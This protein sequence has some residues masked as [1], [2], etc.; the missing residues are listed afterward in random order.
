MGVKIGSY[1]PQTQTPSALLQIGANP[2][3]RPV[4]P[5]VAIGAGL[6]QLGKGLTDVSTA[7]LIKDN[8]DGVARAGKAGSDANKY[9]IDLLEEEK[10]NL[11]GDPNGFAGN[12]LEKFKE[13][14]SKLVDGEENPRGRAML[15]RHLDAV[16]L[17][18]FR[19]AKGYEAQAGVS[20]RDTQVDS[21]YQ[22]YAQM[23]AQGKLTYE[24]AQ[25]A[26]DTIFANIGYDAITRADRA[27][28]Y[29][30]RLADSY[31]Q[32][33]SIND[34]QGAKA[35]LQSFHRPENLSTEDAD[36]VLRS[37]KNLGI[38]PTDLMAVI[39]YETGGTYSPG[40]NGG[41]GG[42]YLGLIQFGPEEQKKYGVHGKQTFGEQ[43]Q[44]VEAYLKDRGLKQGDDL[45]TLYRIINGGNRNASLNASDGNGTI[46]QHVERIKQQ[47]G[48]GALLSSDDR[49]ALRN[50]NI[51]R[52]PNY[53]AAAGAEADRRDNAFLADASLNAANTV[54]NSITPVPDM[55]VDIGKAKADA[56]ALAEQQYG[57]KLD[58]GQKLK[59]ENAV[60]QLANNKLQ[61]VKAKSQDALINLYD[62]L[63]SNGGDLL[64]IRKNVANQRIMSNL[65][66]GDQ[67][68][69]NKYAGEVAT[70]GTRM[71]DWKAYNE[72]LDNPKAL[73]ATNLDAV[74]DQ[75]NRAELTQLKKVQ[76]TL[77]SGET[78]ED[79]IRSDH[80]VVKDLLVQA[81]IKDDAKQGKFY[82]LLQQSMD[83]ELMATGKK[84][85][86]QTRIKELANDLL[87]QTVTSKGYLWD[88]TEKAYNVTVPD[89]ERAKISAALQ[90]NGMPTT[91]YNI[92][93]A[94]LNKL[95]K[96]NKT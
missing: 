13:Y 65:N 50:T 14:K 92:L 35:A 85:L 41:K 87:V 36:A 84:K 52:V 18:L 5:T 25:Q 39:G 93:R 77:Q 33:K 22:N 73:L 83:A 89:V 28:K 75:F 49:A 71:T 1:Q 40:I 29:R 95:N 57:K 9:A 66:R 10:K 86:P 45:T 17:G 3:A 8:A 63:D 37:A 19:E 60:E 43:M 69:L 30:E 94:Y 2:V 53:L 31:W 72:L 34:P 27:T 21:A 61:E 79:N 96:A 91:D 90:A 7:A 42:K 81:G 12:V 32:G 74:R 54:I 58:L 38:D 78:T 11:T 88:S 55:T 64:A 26:M 47:Y 24:S 82:S 68:R 15:S 48:S 56:V 6:Q 62:Q 16:E 59:I 44:A 4:D 23:V 67:E 76:A 20:Y 46:A 80:T 70:G 51:N